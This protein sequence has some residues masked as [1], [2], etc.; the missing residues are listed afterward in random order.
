MNE[1]VYKIYRATKRLIERT[2]ACCEKDHSEAELFKGW[3]DA[4]ASFD[5]AGRG[6]AE[7]Y[8]KEKNNEPVV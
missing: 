4:I 3:K 2:E 8:D 6:Y 1:D 7:R 5:K